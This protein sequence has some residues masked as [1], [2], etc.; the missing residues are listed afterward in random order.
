MYGMARTVGSSSSRIV[1]EGERGLRRASL[2]AF[3]EVFA[4]E[5]EVELR[6]SEAPSSLE[7]S[8]TDPSPL[9]LSPNRDGSCCCEPRSLAICAPALYHPAMP[10]RLLSLPPPIL[11]HVKMEERYSHVNGKICRHTQAIP[12]HRP[13][14]VRLTRSRPYAHRVSIQIVRKRSG[15]IQISASTYAHSD[16]K[17]TP[18]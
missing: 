7:L 14:L 16:S 12:T 3:G 10:S 5:R 2:G 6:R 9:V 11:E 13:P 18:H 8:I 1:K 15:D 17:C 4:Q